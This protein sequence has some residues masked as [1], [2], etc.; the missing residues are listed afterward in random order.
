MR[1]RLAQGMLDS[2]VALSVARLHNQL[3][4]PHV[5]QADCESA[6]FVLGPEPAP[7]SPHASSPNTAP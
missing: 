4:E 5:M 1:R 3:T 6:A 2:E 7:G